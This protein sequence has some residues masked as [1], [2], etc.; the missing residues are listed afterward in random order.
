MTKILKQIT[1]QVLDELL[2]EIPPE[3]YEDDLD[4][5]LWLA[6]RLYRRRSYVPELLL[7]ARASSRQP[8]PNWM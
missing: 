1:E 8:F 6:E 4:A 2:R 7:A 5:L 3:W